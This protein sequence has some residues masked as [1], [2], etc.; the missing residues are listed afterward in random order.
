[1]T[2][3]GEISGGRGWVKRVAEGKGECVGVVGGK[4]RVRLEGLGIVDL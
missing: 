2:Y 3:E 1:M 4:L